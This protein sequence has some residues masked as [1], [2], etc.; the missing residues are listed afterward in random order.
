MALYSTEDVWWIGWNEDRVPVCL[1][2]GWAHRSA[3]VSCVEV[4]LVRQFPC[5]IAWSMR[6]GPMI[7]ASLYPEKSTGLSPDAAGWTSPAC[8]LTHKP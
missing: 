8:F 4:V 2:K 1:C 7:G 3:R 5:W 6:P